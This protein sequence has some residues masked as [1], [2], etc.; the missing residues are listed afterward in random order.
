[1]HKNIPVATIELTKRK[2][3]IIAVKDTVNIEHAPLTTLNESD[4]RLDPIKLDDWL[5]GRSIPA[6]RQNV[7]RLMRDLDIAS[8]SALALQSYGLS[9]S[10]QYWIK[11]TNQA[12]LWEDVNFFQNDFSDDIGKILFNEKSSDD[13]N[14]NVKSPDNSSDGML[15]KRW[16]I[17]DG[18]RILVKGADTKHQL[19]Q[20]PFNE[21]IASQ[22][23]AELNID[24]TPYT[25]I[26][27][28]NKP[29]SLCEVFTTEDTEYITAWSILK[30]TGRDA[31]LS[32]YNQILANCEKLGVGDMRH[33]IEQMLVLDYIIANTDRH[34][35][36][37]GFL[38]NA[39]T[40][41]Y[42][43]FVP[44][45][46]SGTSLWCDGS[47]VSN[48]SNSKPFKKTHSNQIK[49]V[50]D[51]SWYEP[52]SESKLTEIIIS[53]LSKNTPIKDVRVGISEERI[54]KIADTVNQRAEFIT[55]LKRDLTST[56]VAVA[57][58]MP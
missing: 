56:A 53:N 11:P 50:T 48:R 7:A 13:P 46:D 14:I 34:L 27:L 4:G 26:F 57:V 10:D 20:E 16:T 49:L 28:D 44:V 32:E 36:N 55:G 5:E 25:Q 42:E 38:R 8:P 1:M 29:Y 24:H 31:K 17:Q 9:L 18:K 15:R 23:M 54:A 40:L 6:S 12:I 3:S 35:G 21:V 19:Q 45:F 33:K 52:I 22:I 51:L 39:N 37:F 41:E 30:H 58:K 43:G 2:G 47:I